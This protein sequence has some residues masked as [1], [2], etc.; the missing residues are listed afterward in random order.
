MTVH[1][2]V[3]WSDLGL[4]HRPHFPPSSALLR[5]PVCSSDLRAFA[6]AVICAYNALPFCLCMVTSC[7]S[8]GPHL[9]VTTSGQPSPPPCLK[10]PLPPTLPPSLSSRCLSLW[11]VVLFV[12]EF[13]VF[14]FPLECNLHRGG[15]CF[16]FVHGTS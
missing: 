12:H 13:L 7:S 16:C 14:P 11:E 10:Q 6:P 3:W 1:W 8:H 5:T 9:N 2:S 4:P 15:R